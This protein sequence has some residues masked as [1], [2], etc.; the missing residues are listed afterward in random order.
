[1]ILRAALFYGQKCLGCKGAF[2]GINYIRIYVNA[3]EGSF[4]KSRLD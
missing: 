1:M 3:T 4:F 2:L